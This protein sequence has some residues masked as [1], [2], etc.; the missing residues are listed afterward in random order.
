MNSIINS[1]SG[2][3]ERRDSLPTTVTVHH[4][5][6]SAEELRMPANSRCPLRLWPA[7]TR[8]ARC[9]SKSRIIPFLAQIDV[10]TG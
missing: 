3:G 2:L 6:W 10:G 7:L 1:A 9:G 8:K 4:T 5:Y